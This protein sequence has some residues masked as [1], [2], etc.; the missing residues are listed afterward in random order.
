MT[1][2]IQLY[3]LLTFILIFLLKM[4][5]PTANEALYGISVLQLVYILNSLRT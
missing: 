4:N 5:T 2:L 1:I 3:I